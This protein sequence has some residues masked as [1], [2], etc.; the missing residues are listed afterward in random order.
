MPKKADH[1]HKYVRV[2]LGKE[3][4]YFVWRCS[5]SGCPHYVPRELVVGRQSICWRCG[6]VFT[7]TQAV[8]DLKKPHCVECTKGKPGTKPAIDIAD[9]DLD[10]LLKDLS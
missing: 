10:E 6:K 7:I 9:I 5:V 2:Q 1:V 4:N 3:R 8:I